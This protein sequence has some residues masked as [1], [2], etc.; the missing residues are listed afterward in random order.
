MSD[1]AV[2]NILQQ[3]ERLS[4]EERL[5]LKLRLAEREEGDWQREADRARRVAH[6][7][8]I[9]QAVI[10]KAIDDIRHAK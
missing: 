5:D 3:I 4:D 10:D 2:Q 7:K 8:G 1:G 9:T 6:E